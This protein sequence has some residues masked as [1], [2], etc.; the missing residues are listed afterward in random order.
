M[1]KLRDTMLEN[2]QEDSKTGAINNEFAANES[3]LLNS[4]KF[5]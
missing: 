4:N 1:S 3:V 2:V 5:K